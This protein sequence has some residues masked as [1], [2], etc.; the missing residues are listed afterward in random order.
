[1]I[2]FLA[3]VGGLWGQ[4]PQPQSEEERATDFRLP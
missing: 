3:I 4:S 1:V 2:L